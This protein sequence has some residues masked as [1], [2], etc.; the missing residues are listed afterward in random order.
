MLESTLTLYCPN[1]INPQQIICYNKM[2]IPIII[3]ITIFYYIRKELVRCYCCIERL[4]SKVGKGEIGYFL[5]SSR[6]ALEIR[7]G[8]K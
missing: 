6:F 7:G 2:T 3:I 5:C 1:L 8:K 4:N